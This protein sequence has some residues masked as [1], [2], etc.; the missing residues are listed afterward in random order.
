MIEAIGWIALLVG[1]GLLVWW[2]IF[3]G[4]MLHGG[5]EMVAPAIVLGAVAVLAWAI[6]VFWLSPVTI[7]FGVSQ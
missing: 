6:L 2:V 5:L 3:V 7:S 4:M 1:G